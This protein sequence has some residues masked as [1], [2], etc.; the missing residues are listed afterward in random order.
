VA[1]ANCRY[2]SP[3]RFDDEV[4]VKTWIEEAGGRMVK[5]AYE[6]RLAVNDRRLAT[7]FTRHIFL[8]RDFRPTRL[9]EKY[10]AMFG[11]KLAGM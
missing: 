1:E 10:H 9:P 5:F 4:I 2:S 11:M 6:M 8:T 7:G 3:A